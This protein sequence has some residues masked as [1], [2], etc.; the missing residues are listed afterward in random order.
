MPHYRLDLSAAG[1]SNRG[2]YIYSGFHTRYYYQVTPNGITGTL[3]ANLRGG[4]MTTQS[5]LY[6]YHTPQSVIESK[7][8]AGTLIAILFWIFW[9]VVIGGVVYDFCYFENRWLD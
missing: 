3:L 7:Q 2:N 5:A 4:T 6:G 1:I 8:G 9:P